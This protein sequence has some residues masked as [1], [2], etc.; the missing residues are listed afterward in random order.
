MD[1]S[2][3]MPHHVRPSAEARAWGWAIYLCVWVTL[4]VGLAVILGSPLQTWAHSDP[5]ST[6]PSADVLPQEC[7]A[8]QPWLPAAHPTSSAM[9]GA[10]LTV[11]LFVFTAFAMAQGV[12]RWRRTTAL[13]LVLVLGTFTFAIAVHS[14]HHFSAPEKAADC[15]VFSASQHVSGTLAEPCDVH[16]PGLAVTTASPDD[17]DVPVFILRCRFDLPRAPPSFPF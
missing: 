14:V 15:L 4:A 5:S 17:P 6:L 7:Q 10:P 2:R 12:W 8:S 3:H 13:G 9:H 11:I 1:R 16:V